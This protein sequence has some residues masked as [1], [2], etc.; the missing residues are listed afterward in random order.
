MED[1]A[2]QPKVGI[3][4]MILKDGKILLGKRKNAHG[5][6]EYAFPGGHLEHLES[7]VA[8]AKRETAEETGIEIANVRFLRLLNLT[9]YAPKH[10][11]HLTMLADWTAGEPRVLEPEKCEGWAW[12]DPERLPEPVFAT[13][14]GDVEAMRT[15]RNFFDA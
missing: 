1:E 6:G 11:V 3:G 4:V 7:I 5:E 8:C 13:V 2:L 14:A 12:H 9:A 10:Y 15:G